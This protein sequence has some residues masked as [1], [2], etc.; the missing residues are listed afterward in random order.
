M[1]ALGWRL[2]L[3][4][5]QQ[6]ERRTDRSTQRSTSHVHLQLKGKKKSKR[7]AKSDVFQSIEALEQTHLSPKSVVVVGGRGAVEHLPVAVLD[8]HPGLELHRRDLLRIAVTHLH[9]QTAKRRQLHPHRMGQ[10]ASRHT[11]D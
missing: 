2:L 6:H 4:A 3:K 5:Q 1:P 9:K 8:L 7:R 11:S 10:V